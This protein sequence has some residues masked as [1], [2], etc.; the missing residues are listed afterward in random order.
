M[1]SVE[2][3]F[4][5]WTPESVVPAMGAVLQG[6]LPSDPETP[7][8]PFLWGDPDAV[9]ERLGDG[10]SDLEFETGTVEQLEISPAHLWEEAR[11]QS[12]M[13]IVAMEAVDQDDLPALRADMIEAVEP[14]FDD[15]VNAVSMEYRLTRATVR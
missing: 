4:T 12:G 8:P 1:W 14:Y 7:E 9:R 3:T 6:Y 11:T 15:R 5:S 10:V 13:F 2:R